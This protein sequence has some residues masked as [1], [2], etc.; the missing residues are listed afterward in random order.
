MTIEKE[1]FDQWLAHPITEHVLRRVGELADANKQKWIDQTWTSGV[2]DQL[3]LIDLKARS[4]AAK[5]LS[6]LKYEDIADEAE[7]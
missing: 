7:K 3:V 5:D 6:E 2:C 1:D 4:E